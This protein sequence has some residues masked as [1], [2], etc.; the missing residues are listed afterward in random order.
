VKISR[1][2]IRI[3]QPSVGILLQIGVCM[4]Q[5]EGVFSTQPTQT[6]PI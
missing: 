5:V 6:H 3:C 4:G 2:I 1:K